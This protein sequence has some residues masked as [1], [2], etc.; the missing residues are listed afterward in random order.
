MTA[1]VIVAHYNEITL[2]LG[3]RSIFVARLLDNVRKALAGLPVG[4]VSHSTGRVVIELAGTGADAVVQRLVAVPGIANILPARRLE[5]TLEA[6]DAAV[7]EAL[8]HWRPSG[9]FAVRVRR[10]DK[11]FPVSSPEVG[12][13]VGAAI[14][15]ATAARVDL[16]HPDSAVHVFILADQILLAFERIEG[17]GGL[18]VGSAGRVVLL[19]SGGIDSPVAGL[20]MQRRGA[21]LEAV[22]FHSAPM[23]SAASQE[24]ARALCGILARGQGSIRLSLVPFGET[25]AQIVAAVPRSLRVVLYRRMMM[26]IASEFGRRARAGALVTGES[27]GQVASQTLTN[28]SVIERAAS[29]SV[30]RPLVGMDKLEISRYADREG[31][32]EISIQP[33]QDCCSLFVPRHPATAA[34]MDEVLEAEARLDT[35]AM[36]ESCIDRARVE[37]LDAVWPA[38]R[39]PAR[40]AMT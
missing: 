8:E 25:Q 21:R 18:P 23:L 10:A 35:A 38:H 22:H 32:F 30:L 26:R 37:F 4:A 27:L 17:C 36:V 31:T 34:D 1:D 28:M 24:K 7:G 11:R 12:A 9:S 39:S 20:R 3:H 14:V 5:P 29:I 19:L 13:R 33:D 6:L 15:A 40:A 16:D 2:K